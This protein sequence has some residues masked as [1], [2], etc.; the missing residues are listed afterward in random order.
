MMTIGTTPN[1]S[2]SGYLLNLETCS[3]PTTSSPGSDY[4]EEP[5]GRGRMRNRTRDEF[6][7]QAE[8]AH[9]DVRGCAQG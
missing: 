9:P 2:R 8:E 7:G 3:T 1:T 4:D 6:R 5:R